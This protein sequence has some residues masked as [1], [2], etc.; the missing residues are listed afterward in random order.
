MARAVFGG[1]SRASNPTPS[2]VPQGTLGGVAPAAG[3]RP[4]LKLQAG[5]EVY[6]WVLVILE[7]LAMAL[8]RNHFRRFHGG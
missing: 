7:V 6:L 1:H 8:L 3:R 2:G 5:D 4:G